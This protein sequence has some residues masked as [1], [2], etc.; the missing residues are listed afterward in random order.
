MKK[1]II[2]ILLGFTFSINTVSAQDAKTQFFMITKQMNEFAKRFN[3]T[4]V[5]Y[6]DYLKES[7]GIEED[8]PAFSRKE[9]L[10][11]L[12]NHCESMGIKDSLLV[13]QFVETMLQ[14]NYTIHKKDDNWFALVQCTYTFNS[15]QKNKKGND[16]VFELTLQYV[17]NDR[18]GYR[19]KL[20][21][22]NGEFFKHDQTKA[23]ISPAENEV[24]F[25][26]LFDLSNKANYMGFVDEDI[27]IDNISAFLYLLKAD[28]TKLKSIDSIQ[29]H[30]LQIE[31]YTFT[32][33]PFISPDCHKGWSIS[34]ILPMSEKEK[35]DY[36]VKTLSLNGHLQDNYLKCNEKLNQIKNILNH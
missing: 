16:Y 22:V 3:F 35:N 9:M 32:V 14:Q 10:Y 27:D 31:G 24:G 12:I 8:N 30:F 33:D 20:K 19:W 29:Y 7:L 21:A 15:F 36:K 13:Q 34:S 6:I 18:D 4:D 1:L 25:Q 17:G 26:E 11:Y 2:Y 5:N 23:F 28:C